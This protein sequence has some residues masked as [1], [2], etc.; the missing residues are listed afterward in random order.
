MTVETRFVRDDDE[1][2]WIIYELADGTQVGP[3]YE[4][5]IRDVEHARTLL[6]EH[7]DQP[8]KAIV[9]HG[10][11]YIDWDAAAA[12]VETLHARRENAGLN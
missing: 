4:E 2:E 8:V 11:E 1:R 6:T 9:V 12:A 10:F 3:I 7:G 5:Q